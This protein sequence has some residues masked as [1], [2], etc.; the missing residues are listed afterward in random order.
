MWWVHGRIDFALL[1]DR[2][3]VL[4]F[5]FPD[6]SDRFWVVR[7]QAGPSLCTFDPGF[8]VDATV[9]GDLPVLYQVWLG[10]LPLARVLKDGRVRIEG[11]RE[12]VRALPQALQLSPVAELV[13]NSSGA[14]LT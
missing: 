3:L 1:P 6:V 8:Q 4:E 2:R 10:R 5:R 12:V 13:A 14:V 7:D 11:Q 9:V